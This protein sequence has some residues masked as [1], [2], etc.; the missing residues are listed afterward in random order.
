MFIEL[1]FFLGGKSIK[2]TLFPENLFYFPLD[3][4]PNCFMV[5]QYRA[6]PGSFDHVIPQVA[7]AG[8]VHGRI[9]CLELPGLVLF[10]DNAAVFGKG[11]I[12]LKALDGTKLDAALPGVQS[13]L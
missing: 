2:V 5:L 1:T 8:F 7:V 12:A 9:F 13:L 10:P 3:I 4:S 11:I 6:F